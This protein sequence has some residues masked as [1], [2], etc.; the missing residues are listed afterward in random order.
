MSISTNALTLRLSDESLKEI[1]ATWKH[2]GQSIMNRAKSRALW[3]Q[4]SPIQA[5]SLHKIQTIS[6]SNSI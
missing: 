5:I 3:A 4:I 2:S 6:Y 1:A